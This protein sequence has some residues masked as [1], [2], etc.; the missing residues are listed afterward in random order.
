M[1]NA[2]ALRRVDELLPQLL[3]QFGSQVSDVHH[4]RLD[5]TMEFS[6]TT[7]GVHLNG[8][9]EVTGNTVTLDMGIPFPFTLLQGHIEATV[10]EKLAEYFP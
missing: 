8:T 7:R 5:S 4:H 6:F 3:G 9:L 1:T 2:D 10:R